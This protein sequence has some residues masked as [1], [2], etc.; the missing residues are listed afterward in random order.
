MAKYIPL[1]VV[2]LRQIL[3]FN[4]TLLV[5]VLS[6]CAAVQYSDKRRLKIILNS[7]IHNSLSLLPTVK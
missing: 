3:V 4:M 6:G 1:T 2:T 7:E 5:L